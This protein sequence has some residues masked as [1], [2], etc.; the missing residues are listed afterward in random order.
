MQQLANILLSDRDFDMLVSCLDSLL[1]LMPSEP[2]NIRNSEL[3]RKSKL[4]L[5]TLKVKQQKSKHS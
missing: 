2:A 3:R 4:L 1:A 5:R